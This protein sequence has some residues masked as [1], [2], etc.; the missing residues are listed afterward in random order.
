VTFQVLEGKSRKGQ[1][2]SLSIQFNPMEKKWE[3]F[4]ESSTEDRHQL[5]KELLERGYVARY[6][7]LKDVLQRSASSA[8]RYIKQAIECGFFEETDWKKWKQEA[9][10]GQLIR[11]ERIEMGKRFLEKNYIV[12]VN[13]SGRGGRYV[14][15]INPFPELEST[16]F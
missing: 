2:I 3:L 11:E 8:E 15:E 9:K 5:V 4:D 16:D 14:V 6:E 1:R 7:D 13:E 12:L 10:T